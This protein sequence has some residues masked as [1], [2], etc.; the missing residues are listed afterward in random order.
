VVLAA[1]DQQTPG[2]EAALESLCRA[3][4]Y[5][6]YVYV[7]HAG[8]PP[9]D[10]QDLTQE[11]FARFLAK[12]SVIHAD[13]ERGR[14]RTFLLTSLKH[15]LINERTKASRLK[16]GGG[17]QLLSLDLT[18]AESRY[19]AEPA[20]TASPDRLYEKRWA[21][22]LLDRS[23]GELGRDYAAS[24]R[25]RLFEVLKDYIW[26]QKEASG[27]AAIAL[28]LS[29]TETAVKVNVHRLRQRFRELLRAE[30]AQTVA[31]PA[32]I[33]EEL[34]HLITVMGTPGGE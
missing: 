14:F 23:V 26:G 32:E 30:V 2:S 3:Y 16:R 29:M 18:Q 12:S 31:A 10:A 33:D 7:R 21:L 34:R 19:G 28:E 15:F 27:Y 20:D 1:G 4:W 6:L 9:E 13:P 25:G 5:P 11:F 8:H 17:H 24:G 22:T